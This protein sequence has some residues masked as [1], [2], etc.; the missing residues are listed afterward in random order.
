MNLDEAAEELLRQANKERDPFMKELLIM[1]AAGAL[2]ESS[3][4][5]IHRAQAHNPRTNE[6]KQKQK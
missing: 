1:T 3:L 5:T 2:A 6:H 4:P